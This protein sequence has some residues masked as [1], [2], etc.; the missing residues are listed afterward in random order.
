MVS[1]MLTLIHKE[2]VALLR[3][4]RARV[5]LIMPP[6]LQLLVFAFAATLEVKN[7]VLAIYNEDSG[8]HSME[9]ISRLTRAG[10]FNELNYV[11]SLSAMEEQIENQESLLALHFPETFSADIQNRT[12]A[13]LQV[14]VDGR[15]SNSGQIALGYL[16]EITNDLVQELLAG[17]G[18]A[19]PHS[20]LVV[21]HW[22]NPNL[23]YL[24]FNIPGLLMILT[25][26][27]T[28]IVT[29]LSVAREKELGT[30]DQLRV[31]PYSSAEIL[32]GKAI[33][34]YIV[35][36]CEGLV[37]IGIGVFVYGVPFEG[38]FI[39][40]YGTLSVYLLS[41]IGVGLFISSLC[42]T[43]QQA[44]LGVFSF[45]LPAVLL[46]GFASPV[47]NMPGWLQVLDLANPLR[48]YFV[49]SKGVFLRDMT[50]AMAWTHT[51]PILIIGACTLFAAHWL[52]RHKTA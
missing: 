39:L 19:S 3:D 51:W 5:I 35:A 8:P 49:I 32:S 24:W 43:Q 29:A 16:Q 22:F 21:R 6:L 48:H 23:Q 13:R 15:R 12:G 44:I 37:I 4:K 1:R 42:Q 25:T 34:A 38:S 31:S 11:F 9:L 36:L 2:F 20:E 41:L 33:P 26:L 45:I 17:S 46:S 40:L 30:F 50:P 28:M 52:F 27:V 14:I 7:N 10:A 47:E 18:I